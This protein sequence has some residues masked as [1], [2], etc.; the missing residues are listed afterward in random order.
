MRPPGLCTAS[1][2]ADRLTGRLRIRLRVLCELPED[3]IDRHRSTFPDGTVWQ[4]GTAQ[5]QV[6]GPD[7]DDDGLD[8]IA[9]SE[10]CRGCGHRRDDHHR[11]RSTCT[12]APEGGTFDCYCD[13]FESSTLDTERPT[14][15]ITPTTQDGDSTT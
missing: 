8:A 9:A 14:M 11:G 7:V 15:M 6:A 13:D 5:V 4:W 3:H 1:D 12:H 10:R 2:F